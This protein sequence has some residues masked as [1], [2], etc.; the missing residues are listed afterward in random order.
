MSA[1]PGQCERLPEQFTRSPYLRHPR[2]TCG[3]LGRMPDGNNRLD[4]ARDHLAN[5]RTF[6]AWLR[7]ALAVVALSAVLARLRPRHDSS[8]AAAVAIVAAC[9]IVVLVY[10]VVR[11]YAVARDLE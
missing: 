8:T 4:R 9:G 10:G 2:R 5:E 11:Y 1:E 3:I 6:L 7:T